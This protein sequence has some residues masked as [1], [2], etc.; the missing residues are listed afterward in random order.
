MTLLNFTMLLALAPAPTTPPE[1]P[2]PE[3]QASEPQLEAAS[4]DPP[5]SPPPYRRH[6]IGTSAFMLMNA[7]PDDEPPSFYQL[8]YA[9]RLTPKDVLSVEAVTWKYYGPLG[10]QWWHSGDNYPGSV[11]G[12]GIGVAYQ[13]FLWRGLYVGMHAVPFLQ[14]FLDPDKKKLKHGF[15]LFMTARVG[16]HIQLFNNRVFLE[17]SIATTSWPINTGLPD[18]FAEEEGKWGKLFFF[19]PGLHMGVKF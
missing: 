10:R 12:V 16:Y 7:I 11:R 5:R 4:A 9:Y 13:R 2:E 19:E 15:Q 1:S 17:P 3:Q 8:N 18:A 6:S 14:T